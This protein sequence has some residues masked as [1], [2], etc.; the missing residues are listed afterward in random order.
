MATKERK[1][2][3]GYTTTEVSLTDLAILKKK[4]TKRG[5]LM[6]SLLGEAIRKV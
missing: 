3:T 4:A 6:R 1:Q 2:N 5:R